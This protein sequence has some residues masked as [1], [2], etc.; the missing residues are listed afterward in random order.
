MS[1]NNKT[2]S[3]IDYNKLKLMKRNAFLINTSRGQLINEP[4]LF[5]ALKDHI[6][7]GVALDVFNNEPYIPIKGNDL[8]KID[9]VILTPHISSNTDASNR[10]MAEMCISNALNYYKNDLDKVKFIPEYKPQY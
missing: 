5:R 4:D 10:R 2:K 6:I 3:Y 8:R 7:K 9:N 1:V